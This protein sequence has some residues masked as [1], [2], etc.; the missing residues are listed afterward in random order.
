MDRVP[1]AVHPGDLVS[2]ELGDRAHSG[3]AY[4]PVVGEHVERVQLARHRQPTKFQGEANSKG[5]QIEPP[6]G[7]QAHR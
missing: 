6:A 2:E 1:R 7:E 4:D 5:D 3:D